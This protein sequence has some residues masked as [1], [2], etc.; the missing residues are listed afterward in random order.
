[1][2]HEVVPE[3]GREVQLREV[4]SHLLMVLDPLAA[5]YLLT[6]TSRKSM[7]LRAQGQAVDGPDDEVSF[8]CTKRS[9]TSLSKIIPTD[10]RDL[11]CSGVAWPEQRPP[12]LR[13][14]SSAAPAAFANT[15]TL[16]RPTRAAPTPSSKTSNWIQYRQRVVPT[17]IRSA[18]SQ[19]NPRPSRN[20][21]DRDRAGTEKSANAPGP[22]S[23][24]R[25]SCP[26]TRK[27]VKNTPKPAT[28]PSLRGAKPPSPST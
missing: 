11:G 26:C 7:T 18:K 23:L 13:S 14:S 27:C 20:A 28:T 9:S 19:Q 25:T 2:E 21:A 4:I 10:L 17:A 16:F 1:M 22:Y 6:R 24:I 5:W 3:P 12:A 15:N 8:P